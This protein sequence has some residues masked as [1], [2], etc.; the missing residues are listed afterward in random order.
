MAITPSIR[1]AQLQAIPKRDIR[2]QLAASPQIVE[3]GYA[4]PFFRMTSR[5]GVLPDAKPVGLQNPLRFSKPR[6]NAF[7]RERAPDQGIFLK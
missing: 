3:T 4:L 6:L 2:R 1:Q 7:C 5:P